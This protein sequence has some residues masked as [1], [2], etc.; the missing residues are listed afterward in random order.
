MYIRE[1]RIKEIKIGLELKKLPL[2]DEIEIRDCSWD[3][4][5]DPQKRLQSI[6]FKFVK[7]G[8]NSEKFIFIK[9]FRLSGFD[10]EN[11][12][13]EQIVNALGSKLLILNALADQRESKL[14]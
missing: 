11:I 12:M 3:L 2:P 14:W 8:F 6:Y 10:D 7:N 5:E 4:E 9:E 13:V 1:E